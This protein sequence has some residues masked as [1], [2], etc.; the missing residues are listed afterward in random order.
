[1]LY[2]PVAIPPA[3]VI[4]ADN[5][6][7]VNPNNRPSLTPNVDRYL[8]IEQQRTQQRLNELAPKA[9]TDPEA[10]RRYRELSDLNARQLQILTDPTR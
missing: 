5:R 10:A 4:V 9:A 8:R 2:L 3:I 7:Y 6:D 1:M